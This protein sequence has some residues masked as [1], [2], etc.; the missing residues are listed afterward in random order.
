MSF[1]FNTV[2]LCVALCSLSLISLLQG[3]GCCGCCMM[4]IMI[5]IIGMMKIRFESGNEKLK[6]LQ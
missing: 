3:S 6:K 4:T 1:T 5:V 2:E